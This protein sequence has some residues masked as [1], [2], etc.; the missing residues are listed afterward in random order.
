MMGRFLAAFVVLLLGCSHVDAPPSARP[1]AVAAET[2]APAEAP[3]PIP[4]STAVYPWGPTA[5]PSDR[6]DVRFASPPSGF[7][8]VDVAEGSFGAMLRTLPLA[9]EGSP[10]VDYRGIP[11]YDH[12]KHPGIV[13][14]ADLDI[15]NKDLQQCAD[16]IYRL[17]AEW[18]YGRGQRDIGYRSVSGVRLGYK[19]WL[20]GERP[21]VN[22]K[23]IV[24]KKIAASHADD[25]ATFRAYLEELYNWAGTASLERDTMKVDLDDVR[26][27]DFFVLTGQ[28]FG[29]AVLVLDVAKNADGRTALL[30]GQS[31]MP[32]QSFSILRP[33]DRTA[34]FVVDKDAQFVDTP[35]WK[36]FPRSSLRRF[37]SETTA[38]RSAASPLLVVLHGDSGITPAELAAKWERFAAPRDVRV[39]AL[40]CP[41]E[42][43]CNGSWW[44]WDG[45]PSWITAQVDA[46]AAQHP[47]DRA[48]MYL[49]GWSGGASY[50][51][52]RT[53]AFEKTFAALVIHGGGVR[54]RAEGCS[55]TKTPVAFLYGTANPLHDLAERLHD[56]YESCGSEMKTVLLPKAD[57]AAELKALDEH[58]PAIIDWLTTR[59]K[60][61]QASACL[62][63][64]KEGPLAQISTK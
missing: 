43:G 48:R 47:V 33:N 13:A 5:A 36:P 22:G 35:F 7:T 49:A 30:L 64:D 57:H 31:Y 9:P 27:G 60:E 24:M 56:H 50:I 4:K 26:A 3:K 55:G 63:C 53:Q 29:H 44:R 32:A 58:G 39:L 45:D 10:V 1:E 46:F 11:L 6:L 21:I 41:K 61:M 20:A 59:R 18:R 38:S 19:A 51:G 8:R 28:P 25:H 34:W 52:M 54:P 15:G 42:L 17:H 12:G 37:A 23:D 16:T 62:D 2:T 40:T 14:I